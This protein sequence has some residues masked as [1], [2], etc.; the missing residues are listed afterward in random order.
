[1]KECGEILYQALIQS[2]DDF[3]YINDCKSGEFRYPRA[4]VEMFSLPGE[5]VKNPLPYWKEI[6]HPDD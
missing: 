1:M 2:T 4:L 5:V 6:V 3:I